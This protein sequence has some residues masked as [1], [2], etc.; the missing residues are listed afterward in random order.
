[1]GSPLLSHA[2]PNQQRHRVQQRVVVP[3]S[4]IPP[5][6]RV[7]RF[8]PRLVAQRRV[9]SQFVEGAAPTGRGEG[10]PDLLRP[11]TIPGAA[12][13]HE[14]RAP[15]WKDEFVVSASHASRALPPLSNPPSTGLSSR[16]TCFHGPER[17]GAENANMPLSML[18]G[19]GSFGIGHAG[20]SGGGDEAMARDSVVAAA[21]DGEHHPSAVRVFDDLRVV[22]E[23][24]EYLSHDFV[25]SQ[26]RA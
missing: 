26:G 20:L 12:P 11:L 14:E 5:D 17:V 13:V 21:S 16:E 9:G 15:V 3:G 25:W 10:Q 2:S 23:R 6:K 24:R 4:R 22:V 1:M 7:L 18:L 8:T 19:E